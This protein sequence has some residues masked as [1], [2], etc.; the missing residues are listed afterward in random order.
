[1]AHE[2]A[3]YM[4]TQ[5]CKC[6]VIAIYTLIFNYKFMTAFLGNIY[7][8]PENIAILTKEYQLLKLSCT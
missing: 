5:K 1:M 8:V 2:M 6:V 4:I 3:G 7:S